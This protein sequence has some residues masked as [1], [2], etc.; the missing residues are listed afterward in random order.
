[1]LVKGSVV[2]SGAPAGLQADPAL[3]HRH[4]GVD[5]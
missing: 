5:G 3:M 2:Y 4:L 1:V